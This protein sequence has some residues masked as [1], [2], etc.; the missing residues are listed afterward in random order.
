MAGHGESVPAGSPVRCA[1]DACG[2]A[3]AVLAFL[4]PG[5]TFSAPGCARRGDL[6][7]ARRPVCPPR[8]LPSGATAP[9]AKVDG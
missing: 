4:V 9:G 8:G 2:H 7:P 1:P 3:L 6:A 5:E